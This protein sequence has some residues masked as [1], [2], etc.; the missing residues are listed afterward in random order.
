MLPSS[1]KNKAIKYLAKI[2]A[3]GVLRITKKKKMIE[4]IKPRIFEGSKNKSSLRT[5]FHKEK[6]SSATSVLYTHRRMYMYIGMYTLF[7]PAGFIIQDLFYFYLRHFKDVCEQTR[8]EAFK[9]FSIHT[10]C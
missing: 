1:Q 5:Q 7:P 4:N 9:D 6:Y 8:K 10:F 2:L 3:K